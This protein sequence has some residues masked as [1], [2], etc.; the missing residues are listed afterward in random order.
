MVS[1]V[2]CPAWLL[3]RLRQNGGE[4]PF[5]QFMQWALHD[6]DHGAY[7]SGHLAVGPQGDFA[8]SPSLGEDFADLLVD[9]LLD[10]LG[11]LAE[12]CPGERLS[13][14]DVGPGEGTLTAQLISLLRRKAPAWVD[15]LDCVL[16]ECNPGMEL[17][18]K[19]R[20]GACPPIP[21]RWTSLEDLKR[22]PLIGVVVAHELLDALAVERLVLRTGRMQRQMVRLRDRSSSAQIHLAEATFDGELRT[23]FQSECERA[24]MVIPPNGAEDGWTTEWHACVAPWM[25]DAAAAMKQGVLLVVDYA[26]EADRY[27]SCQRS[28]GTLLAYQEQIATNEV[29]RNAGTQDITAHLCVEGVVASAEMNGWRFEGQ[30]RQGEALLALGLA[31][32]FSALQSLPA[33]QLGEALRRRE[34]L[35]RLVDPSCLGDLRWMVFHRQICHQEDFPEQCSRLLRDPPAVRAGSSDTA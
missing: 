28:D 3:D 4:V 21:C 29:L 22:N 24:G 2:C 10:W 1:D 33:D 5:S 25:R 19:R 27:Y 26:L 30:R 23:Q 8:T 34:T 15:S 6:P 20:I 12:L 11:A 31:D 7:G 13:L 32:R 9:Q 35:L 18:Q 17:R 14:V 16:V